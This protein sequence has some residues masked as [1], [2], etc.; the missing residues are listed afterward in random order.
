LSF[1]ENARLCSV[2]KVREVAS[3]S[4]FLENARLCS[5]LQ[6]LEVEFL[7]NARL[8]SVLKVESPQKVLSSPKAL[9]RLLN[10]YIYIYGKGWLQIQEISFS[11]YD[12][13][14]LDLVAYWAL[15]EGWLGTL[16]QRA[17][18]HNTSQELSTFG[19]FLMVS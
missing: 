16:Q 13:K 4:S 11:F 9:R 7:E 18:P 10:I 12:A 14:F 3:K 19:G 15:Q 5:I 2:F 8:C 1:R 17:L 6:G